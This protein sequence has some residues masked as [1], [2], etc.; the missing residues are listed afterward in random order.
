M[1]TIITLN[2]LELILTLGTLPERISSL[3]AHAEKY[4]TEIDGDTWARGIVPVAKP[5]GK[6]P[7]EISI[8]RD[9]YVFTGVKDGLPVYTTKGYIVWH[10]VPLKDMR[11]LGLCMPTLEE[12][13]EYASR[14][15]FLLVGDVMLG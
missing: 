2:G 6:Y 4:Q 15:G 7:P 10:E 14:D 8:L 3:P 1:E 11:F 13:R 9:V 5:S 12:A